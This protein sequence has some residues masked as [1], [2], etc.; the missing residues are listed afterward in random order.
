MTA[1]RSRRIIWGTFAL[2]VVVGAMLHFHINVAVN[3]F[4]PSTFR[5]TTRELDHRMDLPHHTIN[6]NNDDNNNNTTLLLEMSNES[7]SNG[8]KQL[9]HRDHHALTTST[10]LD[11]SQLQQLVVV[12]VEPD[13]SFVWRGAQ[14][15]LCK[16][17]QRE[18][19]TFQSRQANSSDNVTLKL[20]LQI[21]CKQIHKRN[22]HGNFLLGY[23][24]MTVAA[25]HFRADFTL[26]CTED[27]VQTISVST[28]RQYLLWW[29]QS[30][31]PNDEVA[32]Y[33]ANEAL[34]DP[35][36]PSEKD[37][38]KVSMREHTV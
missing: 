32:M 37:A 24:G 14:G 7:S 33:R 30:P 35:P 12:D 38:C 10:T 4:A 13:E 3:H 18:Q 36:L 6:N 15:R 22:Q 28:K 31:P 5:A 9:F 2:L 34:Y 23:Y 11:D 17:I 27:A 16:H 26:E 20:H 19:K 1:V 29:L 21:S 8:T 25:M